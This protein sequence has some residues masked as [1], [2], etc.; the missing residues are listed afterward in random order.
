[1]IKIVW[2]LLVQLVVVIGLNPLLLF[3]LV[4]VVRFDPLLLF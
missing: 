4:I 1:M 3:K 2:F